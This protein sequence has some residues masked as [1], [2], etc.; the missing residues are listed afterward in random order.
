MTRRQR[1]DDL[2]LIAVPEQPTLSPDG[3]RIA[4][5][6]RTCD[7]DRD[8][9]ARAL[10]IVG[11]ASGRPRRL[12]HGS[13]DSAPAWSPD[14]ARVAFLRG[15][16]RPA[17]VWLLPAEGGE[18]EQV[19]DLP[20][21]AGAPVWSPDGSKIAFAAV[22]DRAAVPGE[23]DEA[24]R[25]RAGAPIV[26][27]RLD[28]RADG[29]GLLRTLRRHLFVLDL[30]G[31]DCRQVTDGD[32]HAGDPAWSPDGTRLA[33]TA[34]TAP[35]AD[36][37]HRAPVYV[38]DLADPVSR[39]V[40]A[41]LDRGAGGPAT[42]TRD[43][44][45]LLVAGTPGEPAGHARLLRIPLDGGGTEDLTASLDRNVMPGG[46]AYPG[47][48]PRLSGDGRT[49]LFCAR[50]RGCTHLYAVPVDGGDPRPV[51]AGAGRVVS[52]LSVAGTRAV[53]VLAT[54]ESF[55]EIAVVDLVTGAETVRTDHGAALAGV[56]SFPRVAREFTISDGTVVEGW[57]VRDPGTHGP[58]PLLL[59]VHGGP[60][61]AWNGAADEVHLYHQELAARGWTILLV[62]PR[63]SDGYGERFHTAALGAWGTADAKDLLEPVDALVA[64]G[65][66]DHARLAV[67]GYSYG[68]YMTCYLT[69]HDDRFAAA[70]AGGVVSDL[71]SMAG[72]SDE[73]HFLGVHELGGPYWEEP[74][75]YAA[76]SPLT[77]VDR[78]RT[79]TL[80]IHGADDLR[81]PVGQAQQWHTALR[82]RGVPSEL[83]LYPGAD[84][85]FI[86]DGPPSHR[87]DFNRRVADWLERHT[88]T[89]PRPRL[90]AAH[91]QRRLAVLAERHGIPGAAL[92]ILRMTPG[93]DETVEA[94]TGVLNRETGV[95][96]TTD[97]LFQIGSVSKVWTTTLV[98]QLVDEG[99]LDLDAPLAEVLP[100]LRLA[101]AETAAKVTMRHLLTH[102]S[103]IDG[104][105]FADTGRGDDCLEKYVEAL[106]EVARNHP[107]G[108]TW[109]YCNSG[110]S[111]AG[112]VVEKLT[113]TTW[114]AALRE[115]I[116]TPLGLR[117]T[118]TL[119]E[120]ALL[121]RAAV[122]HVHDDSGQPV[123]AA[124]WQLPRSAGPAGLISSTVADVLAF[125][126]MHLTGGRA[127]DGTRVLSEASAAAMT[128]NQ[129]ELPDRRTS[130]DSWGLGWVR[131][132]WDGRRL[133]G[134][135]GS[136]IGQSAFLRLLPEPGLAVVLLTNRDDADGLYDAL[137]REIF[138]D[139]AGIAVPEPFAPPA[140]PASADVD[141]HAGTYERAGE[142]LEV[143]GGERPR[144]R[145]TATGALAALL[146]ES[147]REQEHDLVRV[148]ED[149][150]AVRSPRT[151]M[152]LPVT[153]Y[154]LPTGERY[155]RLAGRATPKAP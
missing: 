2:T 113:G 34:A 13:A 92:G 142:R 149:L 148:E 121:H 108:A 80:V 17:Q 67:T 19:T 141:R 134:H 35:D 103:G 101:D 98:M 140:E 12:T 81:C 33:F 14:G 85:L 32:W 11:A 117:H 47:A 100:E 120:E 63:G 125:A 64:E 51:L 155:L 16:A 137:F 115:R 66:A 143:V 105:V 114:D 28:Y 70:V 106:A 91:W 126:R 43:G 22:T 40:E 62:N 73:S 112:R 41:G 129:I 26:T 89:R 9:N 133:V 95:A 119:P 37:V 118:T 7:A 130:G 45:A 127:P 131:L 58:G 76:M 145:R 123:R 122:G 49:V 31:G 138:A 78:V 42:W 1:I 128:E 84:H 136:T 87:I 50:D 72:T 139:L 146:P 110:F 154:A 36:L 59:D 20:L 61:N 69:G 5:V 97:S 15:G 116:L 75:R 132:G 4:Y 53:T 30:D 111:L 86:I 3:D 8:R 65:V 82:E 147:E 10:W 18:A 90:D 21:G 74:A 71:T 104:D 83:V 79:P 25:R 94:A 124:I 48:A 88:A 68:G 24:R 109:S 60:H 151:G 6:L 93:G 77:R 135:D 23:D 27:G 150:F 96:A 44:S 107:L 39:P 102:T 56:G 152:W 55:G 29:A 46:P 57:I 52:G 153:F 99:R 38:L 54:P 144:L